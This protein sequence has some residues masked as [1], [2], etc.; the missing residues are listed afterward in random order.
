MF[1]AVAKPGSGSLPVFGWSI[2]LGDRIFFGDVSSLHRASVPTCPRIVINA[3]DRECR[4]ACT[5]VG[6]REGVGVA[7]KP[8]E[9]GVNDSGTARPSSGAV[10]SMSDFVGNAVQCGCIIPRR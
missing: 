10:L 5:G 8:G 7:S 2:A 3:S 9:D 4:D 1:A 6:L